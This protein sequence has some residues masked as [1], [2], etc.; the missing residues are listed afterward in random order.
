MRKMSTRETV[1]IGLLIVAAIVALWYGRGGVVGDSEEGEQLSAEDLGE[2]PTVNIA[3]LEQGAAGYDGRGRSLFQYYTPP[4]P[5]VKRTAPPPPVKR[6]TPPPRRVEPPKPRPVKTPQN[7]KPT[8]PPVD[9]EYVGF[10]G[11]KDDRIAVFES[12]EEDMVL[13]R[14]GG[15]IEEQFRLEEFV[16]EGVVL[17]YTDRRFDGQTTELMMKAAQ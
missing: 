14:V 17:G 3:L 15:E 6:D 2:P 11:P 4:P 16:Y 12:R 5:P 9:F 13:V 7:N 8:P 10:L 1:M